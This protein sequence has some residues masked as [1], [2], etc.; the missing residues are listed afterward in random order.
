LSNSLIVINED[1]RRSKYENE[2]EK[3]NTN[4]PHRLYGMFI[5]ARIAGERCKWI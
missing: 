2:I 5:D 4:T 3:I 1:R